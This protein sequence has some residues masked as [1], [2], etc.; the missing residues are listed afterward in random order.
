MPTHFL[1]MM[2]FGGSGADRRNQKLKDTFD[3]IN[4]TRNNE[5]KDYIERGKTEIK[6]IITNNRKKN[7]FFVLL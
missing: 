5:I 4:N 6:K 7:F 2:F 1:Q 3:S